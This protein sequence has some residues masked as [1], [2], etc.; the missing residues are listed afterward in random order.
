MR[1]LF[2]TVLVLA[3]TAGCGTKSE[4]KAQPAATTAVVPA[5]TSDVD[6]DRY[7]CHAISQ[8]SEDS[9]D[10]NPVY[11][12]PAAKFALDAKYQRLVDAA[13]PVLRATAV[14][15]AADDPR[16]EPNIALTR[17][18]IELAEACG[19]LYGDGPW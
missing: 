17:A 2:T 15:E 4:P 16:G 13:G 12:R 10:L 3:L 14:V 7:A 9:E 5:P 18:W 19:D 8:V 11:T 1:T 6:R